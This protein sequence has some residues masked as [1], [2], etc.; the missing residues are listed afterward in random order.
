MQILF[1][2]TTAGYVGGVEQHMVLASDGLA[3][4]SHVCSIAHLNADGRACEEFF[5][6]FAASY[7]LKD[8]TW[9]DV[10]GQSKP[11][12]IYIHKWDAIAPILTANA[13]RAAVLRMFHDH[14]IY[15]PR[16]HKYYSWNRRICTH[17]AGLACYLDLAFL[18]RRDGKLSYAPI[19]P[20]LRELKRNRQLDRVVVGSTYMRDELIRNGF[21]SD[22]IEVIPPSVSDFGE[23]VASLADTKRVLYVGQLVRGKGVDTLLEAL[24]LADS[25]LS[26]AIV[27]AGND[28]Q[29]I[30]ALASERGLSDRV[31]FLGWVDHQ[32]LSRYYDEAMCVCVPSRW[33]EPFGM[34]GLEAM[35]R[36]RP[37]IGTRVGGIPDWLEDEQNGLL[38]PPNDAHMLAEAINRICLDYVYAQEL[39]KRG[40]QRVLAAFSFDAFVTRLTTLMQEMQRR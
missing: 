37:V 11:D 14:D 6:H 10:L 27:G 21:R 22:T 1:V 31:T 35:L 29:Y 30:K 28:E 26:L 18:E 2:N 16:R 3:S 15:C 20:K 12:I 40:R 34:V 7:S 39:G 13:G 9:E 5:T 33:P 25:S 38:V 4:S 8:T 24:A 36:A 19:L 17:R 32:T 23:P